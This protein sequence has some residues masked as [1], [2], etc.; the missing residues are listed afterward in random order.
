M[1]AWHTSVVCYRWITV[2]NNEIDGE[3]G[4]A[5]LHTCAL[6]RLQ[7][8]SL[9]SQTFQDQLHGTLI[10]RPSRHSAIAVVVERLGVASTLPSRPIAMRSRKPNTTR[11]VNSAFMTI[12]EEDSR[13]EE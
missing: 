12:A 8:P 3:I 1:G 13:R 9:C 6:T 11:A 2:L 4:F 10:V 5:I 7:S